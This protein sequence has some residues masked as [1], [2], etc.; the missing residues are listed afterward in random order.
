MHELHL[1]H[2]ARLAGEAAR[3]E[4]WAARTERPRLSTAQKMELVGTSKES[5][6]QASKRMLLNNGQMLQDKSF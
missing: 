1:A 2:E 4:G 6:T 3:D 5:L